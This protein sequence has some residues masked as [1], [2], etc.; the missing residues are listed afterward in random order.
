VAGQWFS[1]G[2]LV[3]STNKTDLHDI[4]TNQPTTNIAVSCNSNY[5]KITILCQ[6]VMLDSLSCSFTSISFLTTIYFTYCKNS[7]KSRFNIIF[8]FLLCTFINA[9]I[10]TRTK[11]KKIEAWVHDH[12]AV[13]RV[14]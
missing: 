10:M 3:S 1:Q 14:T 5:H 12:K 11:K 13:C 9:K 4:A 6:S 2:T 8:I 7:I